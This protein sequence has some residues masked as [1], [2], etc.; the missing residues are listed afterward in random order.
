M[1]TALGCARSD[2]ISLWI[3]QT[4]VLERLDSLLSVTHQRTASKPINGNGNGLGLV[5]P[6]AF[7]PTPPSMSPPE[8]STLPDAN[9]PKHSETGTR[10][11]NDSSSD[12]PHDQT[13]DKQPSRVPTSVGTPGSATSSLKAPRTMSDFAHEQ[14]KRQEA[15]PHLQKRSPSDFAS[16]PDEE[17]LDFGKPSVPATPS[18]NALWLT[19]ISGRR[20]KRKLGSDSEPDEE[21][22]E[23][24]RPS[25]EIKKAKT[26]SQSPASVSYGTPTIGA[27]QSELAPSPRRSIQHSTLPA[28]PIPSPSYAPPGP[29]PLATAPVISVDSGSDEEDDDSSDSEV[30]PELPT[31]NPSRTVEV[32]AYTAADGDG[33]EDDFLAAAFNN[34]DDTMAVQGDAASNHSG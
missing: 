33:E 14:R 22:L 31:F 34:P 19:D 12:P 16:E 7:P 26:A 24:G 25:K 18:S 17:I 28:S 10:A 23:F 5:Q 29:S 1:I 15:R 2:R 13:A 32:D 6:N 8:Y 30:E 9:R 3:R 4:L 20:A 11:K 27:S 21:E